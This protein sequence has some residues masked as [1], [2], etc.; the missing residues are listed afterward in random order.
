MKLQIFAEALARGAI[1]ES[2][3]KAGLEALGIGLAAKACRF[4][5]APTPCLHLR[6]KFAGLSRGSVLV[7][8]LEASGHG[9]AGDAPA[10]HRPVG[11]AA[12]G[13]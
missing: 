10:Q 8:G 1:A 7:V 6:F 2:D 9:A 4:P 12:P 5:L 11:S 3:A 13:P